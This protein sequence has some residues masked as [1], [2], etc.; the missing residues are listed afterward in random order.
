MG[1]SDITERGRE[2]KMLNDVGGL[3]R[4]TRSTKELLSDFTESIHMFSSLLSKGGDTTS[5]IQNKIA[6]TR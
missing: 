6:S 5:L 4:A 3:T 2:E 1:G